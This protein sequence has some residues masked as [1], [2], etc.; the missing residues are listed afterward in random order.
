MTEPDKVTAAHLRRVAVV[1]IRQ[2]STGQLERN[3]ESTERQYALGERAVA[4]GWPRSAVR[5]I[6]AD[7]GVS[8]AGAARR[9][10]FTDLMSQVALGQVGLVLA[11]EVSRLARNNAEWYRMLDLAGLTDTLIGD[12]D[13]LYHPGLFNDR[14]VLG[15]KGT[16][17]EAELHVLRARLNGG[18]RN[19]A[20]RGELRRKLPAG[21]VW[22]PSPGEILID[23][24]EAVAG[25]IRTVFER[26][27]VCGS[28]H[29]VWLWLLEH[30][31]KVPTAW[32]DWDTVRWRQPTYTTVHHILTNPAYA[33]VYC[34]GKTRFERYL[35]EDSGQLRTRRVP[36][37][38]DQ[39]Q[40]FLRDHHAG[41]LDYA[42][43]QAN[44]ERIAANSRPVA[45]A[46]GTGAVREGSALLQGL[47]TCGICGRKLY[48]FYQGTPVLAPTY[49]CQIGRFTKGR[50]PRHMN[51]A[52][53]LVDPPV[54]EAFL[55]ALA[56][57]ALRA[58]LAAA[59]RIEAGHELA[60]AQWRRE[61]ERTAYT[62]LKAE[63]R[64]RAVDPEN[65]LV[66]RSLEADWETA[67]AAAE[68]ARKELERREST[69]PRALSSQE[70]DAVLALGD[71]LGQVW[72]APTTTHRDRKE[73]L[74]T[75]L[76]EVNIT[77]DRPG[78]Q[79]RLVVRWKGGRIS[80]LTVGLP[81]RKPSKYQTEQATLDL[82]RQLAA[83]HTDKEIAA[84]FTARGMRTPTGRDFTA[85]RVYHLRHRWRIPHR[86]CLPEPAPGIGP[87]SLSR[88]A[89]ELHVS[90]ATMHHWLH[91]GFIPGTR[92]APDAPWQVMLTADVRARL[93]DQAPRGW[94]PLTE[95]CNGLGADRDTVM[96][97]IKDG[98][99]RAVYVRQY[100]R[101]GLHIP[102]TVTTKERS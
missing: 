55:T 56:P 24:D 23:P 62:A 81:R 31:L 87:F 32:P 8:G 35:D 1:Y 63:R 9:A 54:V 53:R 10:G 40:V 94:V 5:Y 96:S 14:L 77:V 12:A 78:G 65:R 7:L 51:I 15:L 100:P 85:T 49:H 45:N 89:R 19:K 11:L 41:Y 29:G 60:L 67:L 36:L 83:D 37:P 98:T 17:S 34:Y 70:R 16:M 102:L 72:D 97:R 64:Y 76:E 44:L 43:F 22:G 30:H 18:M 93:V 48:I 95:A 59:D 61:V 75:L 39:W 86:P 3:T 4:L 26:F 42:T 79:I 90:Q 84:I 21:L 71:D 28:V 46:P 92:S 68:T 27:A 88:A 13:G 50:L 99:L 57:S 25:A 6:D 66:A 33:G 101:R 47:A 74:R 20:A 2:S 80:E 52:A 58:C 82:L 69:R 38:R 91:S 73:L